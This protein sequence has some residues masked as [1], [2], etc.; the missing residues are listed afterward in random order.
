MQASNLLSASAG[1]DSPEPHLNAAEFVD[2]LGDRAHVYQHRSAA[3]LAVLRFKR[4]FSEAPDFEAALRKRVEELRPFRHPAVA[5]ARGVERLVT[6]GELV[7]LSDR[8][9]GRRLSDL[10]QDASG[11]EFAIELVGQLAP[12]L[13]ALHQHN[14]DLSHGLLTPDRIIVTHEG[15][16]VLTETPVSAAMSVLRLPAHRVRTE[17]QVAVPAGAN[18]EMFDGCADV[19][20][21][22]FVALSLL[23]ARRLDAADYPASL[24][25]W[26]RELE[27]RAADH[28]AVPPAL[29]DW[30]ERALQ[31]DN[32]KFESPEA[33]VEAFAKVR[34]VSDFTAV[35]AVH[36][37]VAVPEPFTATDGDTVTAV[38]HEVPGDSAV[39]EPAGSEFP[40]ETDSTR[41]P[42]EIESASKRVVPIHPAVTAPK[43]AEPEPASAEP[44]SAE[45]VTLSSKLRLP[46]LAATLAAVFGVVAVL[47][48]GVIAMLMRTPEVSAATIPRVEPG[49]ALAAAASQLT[50]PSTPD[51]PSPVS[52]PST[53]PASGVAVPTPPAAHPSSP[54]PAPAPAAAGGRFGG[55]KVTSAFDLQAFENGQPVGSTSGPIALAEGKHTIE[56]VNETLGFRTRANV[57]V[58]AGQM[59]ALSLPVPNGRISIN[60]SPWASVTIDGAAAGDTPIANLAIPIGTHDV[61]FRHP[62]FGEQRQRIVV[63]VEGM[64]RVGATMEPRAAGS[65]R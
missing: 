53:T 26:M 48:A 40:A 61:V 5:G 9:Q 36:G 6:G 44:D 51:A 31:L 59:T 3:W 2:A 11:P 27:A 13:A 49:A 56:L 50:P 29:L 43:V 60:A 33:A 46:G 54:E 4:E 34:R 14:K 65:N 64:T 23:L 42:V 39:E 15:R 8:V 35:D 19:L 12:A 58:K 38:A 7:L 16:L 18:V 10:I 57:D 45:P 52:G 37:P 62:E 55:L 22:G 17:L 30:V 20:Q 47:E 25:T 24:P 32:K 28:F 41:K 21:L 63:K 1:P